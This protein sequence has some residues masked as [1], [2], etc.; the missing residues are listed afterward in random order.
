MYLRFGQGDNCCSC[1]KC[2]PPPGRVTGEDG[3]IF[4]HPKQQDVV[5]FCPWIFSLRMDIFFLLSIYSMLVF[6]SF[7]RSRNGCIGKFSVLG[8]SM[9][10]V[11]Y[12]LGVVWFGCRVVWVSYGLRVMLKVSYGLG[13]VWSGYRVIWVS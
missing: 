10:L 12:S 7:S 1:T 13:V 11:W 2:L 3:Q 9:V 6:I 5:A 8:C 4:T